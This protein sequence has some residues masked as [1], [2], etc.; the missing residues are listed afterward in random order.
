MSNSG[1]LSP[2]SDVQMTFLIT[3]KELYG[4]WCIV[5]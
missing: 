3:Y 4:V 1:P 5:F 2:V